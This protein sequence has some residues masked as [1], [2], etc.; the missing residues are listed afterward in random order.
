MDLR[1]NASENGT[2]MRLSCLPILLIA[3]ACAAEPEV[4]GDGLINYAED[5]A[6]MN[7]AIAAARSSLPTFVAALDDPANAGF[8]LKLAMP[9]ANSVEHIWADVAERRPD[10]SFVTYLANE[11]FEIDYA[12][13]D[14]VVA[15]AD[16]VSDWGYSRDG[17]L[18]G[19]Y[20]TRVIL[21]ELDPAQAEALE[22]QLAPLP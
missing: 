18:H 11:P 19:H 16:M 14:E 4:V 20:T 10:G 15:T 22:A 17:L 8:S 7:A 6:A 21:P 13:G 5:D 12:Y 2:D 1:L 9:T 3:A